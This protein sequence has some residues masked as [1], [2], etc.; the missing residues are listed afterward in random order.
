MSKSLIMKPIVTV[1][2]TCFNYERFVRTAIESVLQQT[3][4]K[5]DLIVIDD[6][7]TDKSAEIINEYSSKENVRIFFQKNIGL[8]KTNNKAIKLSKGS[9][10]IRL[11]ADDYFH[12]KAIE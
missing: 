12:P 9:Y 3:Y 4:K 5:I 1:Y 10:I 8:N 7:S 11:D 2:I 6:G